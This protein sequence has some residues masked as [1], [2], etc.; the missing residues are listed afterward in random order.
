MTAPADDF[1]IFADSEHMFFG[2][3]EPYAVIREELDAA[4]ASGKKAPDGDAT[5]TGSVSICSS[6]SLNCGSL[7]ATPVHHPK[8]DIGLCFQDETGNGSADNNSKKL[9]T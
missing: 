6:P 2:L 7:A 9:L 1:S 3:S 4:A 5:P 8:Q